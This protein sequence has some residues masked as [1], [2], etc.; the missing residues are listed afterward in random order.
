MT[1]QLL[2]GVRCGPHDEDN[3]ENHKCVSGLLKP[4]AGTMIVVAFLVH[5]YFILELVMEKAP[6]IKKMLDRKVNSC[7]WND[8]VEPMDQPP[9]AHSLDDEPGSDIYGTMAASVL[10][11]FILKTSSF[12]RDT[13][14]IGLLFTTALTPAMWIL[15]NHKL[16][17]FTKKTL[18][19]CRRE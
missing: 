17:V 14:N 8:R 19:C 18:I 1:I 2:V 5:F 11:Y 4:F 9:L 10:I 13:T 3:L 6:R 15:N 16:M 7:L 12:S